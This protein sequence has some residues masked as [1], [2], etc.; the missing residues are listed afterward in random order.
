MAQIHHFS[1]QSADANSISLYLQ[2]AAEVDSFRQN[3]H[4]SLS[5]GDLT[6]ESWLLSLG[7]G[8]SILVERV[9]GA[10][11]QQDSNTLTPDRNG[12]VPENIL[13]LGWRGGICN[14][15]RSIASLAAVASFSD[16]EFNWTWSEAMACPGGPSF[17]YGDLAAPDGYLTTSQALTQLTSN[18]NSFFL[19]SKPVSAWAFYTKYKDGLSLNVGWEEFSKKYAQITRELLT[20]FIKYNSVISDYIKQ[21]EHLKSQG[22]AGM[23]IRRTD[24]LEHIKNQFPGKQLPEPEQYL[25]ELKKIYKGQNIYLSTDEKL[26]VDH[27]KDDS[28]YNYFRYDADFNTNTLR[29][30]SF[31]HS[32]VDL[33]MLTQASALVLTPHSSFSQFVKDISDANSVQIQLIDVDP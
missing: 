21:N 31:W 25:T 28:T 19:E 9:L 14:R 8:L 29:Q 33:E 10:T 11:G 6:T 13:F 2:L 27:F 23:H 30:T 20:T 16:L 22:Y 4:A 1:R 26:V 7:R 15:L 5:T 17:I 3:L 18:Q 32:L 24:F 12:S